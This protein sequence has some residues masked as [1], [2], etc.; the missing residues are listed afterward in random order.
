MC[1]WPFAQIGIVSSTPQLDHATTPI[2]AVV[3]HKRDAGKI[4]SLY[5]TNKF[6]L[7]RLTEGVAS[8]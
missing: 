8:I 1:K 4:T 3:N 5:G 6:G 7:F 2:V